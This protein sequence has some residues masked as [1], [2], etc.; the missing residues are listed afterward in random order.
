MKTSP[1]SMSP[2]NVAAMLRIAYGSAPISTGM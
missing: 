1:S 2:A